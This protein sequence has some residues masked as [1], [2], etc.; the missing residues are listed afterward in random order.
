MNND[1][2]IYTNKKNTGKDFFELFADSE[3]YP[4]NIAERGVPQ[5][6]SFQY[7]S[8]TFVNGYVNYINVKYAIMIERYTEFNIK[9]IRRFISWLKDQFHTKYGNFLTLTAGDNILD[10]IILFGETEN[11]YWYIWS[12]RDCSDC[13]IGSIDK[14][15]VTDLSEFRDTF[16]DF[17]LGNGYH[18]YVELPTPSG[19]IL[20]N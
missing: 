10:D 16:I 15:V 11:S 18:K 2:L 6:T 12:D 14:T 9:N 20:L 13:C 4:E 17:A 19:F 7:V 5:N 8:S 3:D 1:N